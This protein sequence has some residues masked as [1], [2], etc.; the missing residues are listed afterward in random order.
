M[1]KV[2]LVFTSMLICMASV[3]FSQCDRKEVQD[4]AKKKGWEVKN[5]PEADEDYFK[6]MDG[7]IQLSAD[8]VKG[9]NTWLVY[10]AGND[11][12]WD[13]IANK[14]FGSTDLL[15][16]V[17]SYP[18]SKYNRDIR[19]SY[20]GIMNEPGFKK[21]TKPD[22]YGLWLDERVGEP[23]PFENA[24]K[25]PGLNGGSFYGKASGVVG[26]RLFPNPDFDEE[27][28][29]KWD[30]KRYYTDENYYLNPQLVRPYRVAMSCGFCHASPHPLNPPAD[31]ENPEWENLS[32]NIG[33]QYFWA[34][35]VFTSD[36]KPNNFI[37]QLFNSSPP[38]ALETSMIA[39]DNI[40]NPRTMN[41]IYSV[42]NRL[43]AAQ[44]NPKET[45][46]GGT[47]NLK[48]IEKEAHVPH[49]LKDGADAVGI[50]GALTRVYFNIGSF[51]QEW[52][53][54]FNPLVGGKPQTPIEVKV[55]QNNSVYFQAT[56]KLV[57][58]LAKFFLKAA[59]PH[60]LKDAPG[61]AAYL[62]TDQA[63][64]TQG[65]LV[66]ADN[67]ASC[68]SS[69]QPP[70]NKDW[71]S[72]E[73][74]Q[75]M[76]AEVVKPDFLDNN[77]L[78]DEA[79]HPVTVIGTNAGASL[80]SNALKGHVWDNFSSE[81]YKNLPA[82]GKIKV[83]HPLNGTTYDYQMPGGGRGYYRTPS[84]ISMWAT[85]PYF[86]NNGL[87]KFTNDPS[88]AGRM[89]AFDDAAQKLL[90][91]NKR[92]ETDC[93]D[94]WGLPFCPPIYRTT[95]ESYIRLHKNYLPPIFHRMLE[96]G[97]NELRIGP[98]PKGTPINLLANIDLE[99]K[100]GLSQAKKHKDLIG[101]LINVKRSLRQIKQQNL[102]S[103]QATEVLKKLVPD[104]LSVSK[105]PDFVVDRGH[106]FG[107]DLSDKDKLALVEFLK[108]F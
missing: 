80:A 85:A 60:H 94:K 58:N 72:E 89:E 15:K 68:H 100:L 98:I 92:S 70:N 103:E 11:A 56:E 2:L 32:S 61:G 41:A 53:Q 102:N 18:G 75:W 77:Y 26:L 17:S 65:K 59:G 49:I 95:E 4:E 104:L 33:A 51:H 39:N 16:I 19:F 71:R 54:H 81:T 10:T 45:M 43:R 90:W 83:Q 36:L 73:Y 46:A 20:F 74:K 37:W 88:V 91:P 63:L 87:G 67:C 24:A 96:K 44:N 40:N 105:S 93:M 12:F 57:N 34:G 48:N 9:R 66:F 7:K 23:D 21:A 25:Y 3:L 78:S 69:K 62:K 8:E 27:A 5:I 42:G 86:H 30:G 97:E 52:V 28:K 38:G 64:L 13:Y 99:I 76:R 101:L 1:K 14:S 47:L 82:V 55:A 22:E 50:Q 108:T 106:E 31:P 35:R 107:K 29:K 6:D 84:L 79:R